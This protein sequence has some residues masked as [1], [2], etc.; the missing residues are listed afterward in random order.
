MKYGILIWLGALL[1]LLAACTSAVPTA[2]VP[3]TAAAS[4][5]LMPT[6]TEPGTTVTVT[7][8]APAGAEASATPTTAPAAETDRRAVAA[9]E[10]LAQRLDV[11][12]EEI[13]VVSI[14]GDDFPAGD[15]GCPA[16]KEPTR[17]SLGFVTGYRISLT[18]SGTTYYYHTHGGQIA[19]CGTE[20]Q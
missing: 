12:V 5:T 10:D 15:L 16:P 14:V 4:P 8:S 17:P 19:F 3:A 7:V 2:E 13:A 9:V 20:Q 6:A 1:L 18:A 11:P